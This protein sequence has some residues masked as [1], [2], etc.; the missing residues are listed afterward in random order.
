M[1]TRSAR[2]RSWTGTPLS[3][4][5]PETSSRSGSVRSLIETPGTVGRA[6]QP[7][8]VDLVAVAVGEGHHARHHVVGRGDLDLDRADPRGRPAT[9]SPSAM[10][11]AAR[12]SGCISSWCRGLPLV[13]RSELCIQE[14]LSRWCRRPISSSS[15]ASAR[16]PSATARSRA[17]SSSDQ[18]RARSIR[19]SLVCSRPGTRAAADRGR[20]PPGAARS[21]AHD[22]VRADAQQQRRSARRADGAAAAR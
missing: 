8:A 11:R 4:A 13:S 3:A 9:G 14:L 21:V 19:W 5:L 6:A 10:P 2:P 18:R 20:R 12:S 15:S 7:G 1:S 17:R 16:V 22:A